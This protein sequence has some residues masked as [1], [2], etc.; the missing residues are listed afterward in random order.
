MLIHLTR[1]YLLWGFEGQES[2]SKNSHLA[3]LYFLVAEKE[4]CRDDAD[5]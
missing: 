5:L 1:L 3:F 4:G 2:N